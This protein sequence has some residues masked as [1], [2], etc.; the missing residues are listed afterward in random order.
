M[1]MNA[2]VEI[3]ES[4]AMQLP[5]EAM[6]HVQPHTAYEVTTEDARLILAPLNTPKPAPSDRTPAERAESFRQ[7]ADALPKRREPLLP[8]ESLRRENIYD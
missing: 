5:P 7:W 8:D 4:G 6:R 3:S 2:I 1:K